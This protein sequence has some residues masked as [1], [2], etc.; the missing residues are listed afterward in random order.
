[1][2]VQTAMF[3]AKHKFAFRLVHWYIVTAFGGIPL[4]REKFIV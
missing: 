4:W 3:Q 1:M 2:N